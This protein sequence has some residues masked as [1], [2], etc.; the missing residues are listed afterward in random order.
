MGNA[1]CYTQ[2]N[3]IKILS[4]LFRYGQSLLVGLAFQLYP[5]RLLFPLTYI[6]G[7]NTEEIPI[8]LPLSEKTIFTMTA[9]KL[10]LLTQSDV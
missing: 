6:V 9:Y 1:L 3:I 10:T 2:D 5:L 7:S 4:E 8:L